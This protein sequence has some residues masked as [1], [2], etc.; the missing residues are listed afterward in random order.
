MHNMKREKKRAEA[1]DYLAQRKFGK[2]TEGTAH[3]N[4]HSH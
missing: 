4:W 2:A 1:N 3:S